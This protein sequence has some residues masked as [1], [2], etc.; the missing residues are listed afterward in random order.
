MVN[1]KIKHAIAAVMALGLSCSTNAATTEVKPANT[2]MEM[3]ALPGMEKCYGI[4]T[5]GMNDCGTS[6]HH[7]AGE[8]KTDGDKKEWLSV[9]TGLCN[10]IVGGNSAAT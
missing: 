4:A 5:A 9:P 1:D 7:C 10:K 6:N 3:S 8:A 2:D